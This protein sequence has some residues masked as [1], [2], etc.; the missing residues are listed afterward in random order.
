MGKAGS[1]TFTIY[2]EKLF[3]IAKLLASQQQINMGRVMWDC[4]EEKTNKLSRKSNSAL[5]GFI[6]VIQPPKNIHDRKGWK[7]YV[8]TLDKKDWKKFDELASFLINLTNDRR[9]EL[10]K[11]YGKL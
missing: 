11:R 8:D 6:E 3:Q 2:D 4:L 5:Y 1:T 9:A 10:L 7:E